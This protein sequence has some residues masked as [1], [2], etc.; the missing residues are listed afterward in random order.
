MP[1]L[2]TSHA[3]TQQAREHSWE[4]DH[5]PLIQAEPEIQQLIDAGE[6]E[7]AI[8]KKVCD[9]SHDTH[10][11]FDVGKIKLIRAELFSIDEVNA[12]MSKVWGDLDKLADLASLAQDDEFNMPQQD[13]E[14]MIRPAFQVAGAL[15]RH[16][17]QLPYR[18]A[19]LTAAADTMQLA[20]KPATFCAK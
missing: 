17:S 20:K 2:L 11:V 7:D 4:N 18:H 15:L 5:L 1:E 3:H 6:T 16:P 13:L 9:L 14:G 8:K 10:P 12:Q 19:L